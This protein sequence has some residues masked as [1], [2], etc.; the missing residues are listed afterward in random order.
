MTL[1]LSEEVGKLAEA[2]PPAA[3]AA[4]APMGFSG[5]KSLG[6]GGPA[7]MLNPLPARVGGG[8]GSAVMAAPTAVPS[9]SGAAS[10]ASFGVQGVTTYGGQSP[11]YT[12]PVASSGAAVAIPSPRA[13]HWNTLHA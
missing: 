9:A 6:R 11:S 5:G 10:T 7:G 2:P 4:G 3:P 1:A 13:H 8:G 12:V